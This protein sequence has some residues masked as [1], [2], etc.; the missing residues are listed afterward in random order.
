VKPSFPPIPGGMHS[1]SPLAPANQEVRCINPIKELFCTDHTGRK[2]YAKYYNSAISVSS[3]EF[4]TLR[5]I[6]EKNNVF[7]S[8]GIIEKDGATLYCTAVLINREGKL[9]S[10]HRKV[11]YIFTFRCSLLIPLVDSYRSR[12]TNMGSWSRRWPQGYRYRNW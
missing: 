11:C 9:L 6:A 3:S 7:L 4:D 5:A 8:V 12:E 1:M 10:T 2:W